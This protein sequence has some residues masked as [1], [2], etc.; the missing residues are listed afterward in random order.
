MGRTQEDPSEKQSSSTTT[1]AELHRAAE[2]WRLVGA[3]GPRRK[4]G[5]M[6]PARGGAEEKRGDERSGLRAPVLVPGGG[7]VGAARVS[8]S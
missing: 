7:E 4:R 2:A 6:D 1:T 5:R 3:L 8:G